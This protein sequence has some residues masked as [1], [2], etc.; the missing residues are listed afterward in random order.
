MS[1]AGRRAA[2][3]P[4]D[5]ELVPAL[6]EAH[7]HSPVTVTADNLAQCR[8][9]ELDDT[10]SLE[11]LAQGGVEVEEW[12]V[13]GPEGAP[14]I[15]LLIIRPPG[16]PSLP[17]L[18]GRRALPCLYHT[19]GGGMIMGNNRTGLDRTLGWVT[20]PGLVIVSVE[21]RLA[22]EHPFPAGVE[23]CYAGLVWTASHPEELGIDPQ[24]LIVGGGSAGG[25][26]A[27]ACALMARDRGGPPLAGQ[28]LIYPMIDDRLATESTWE[29]DGDGIWDGSSN[30]N[31][32]N[33]LLGDQRGS[34]GVSPYAAPARRRP[35]RAAPRLHRT[36]QRGNLPG[37]GPGLRPP[38]LGRR[39]GRRTARVARRIPRLRPD[40]PRLCPDP[41]RAGGPPG[42]APPHPFLLADLVR[43]GPAGDEAAL[44]WCFDGA[45]IVPLAHKGDRL[46]GGHAVEDGQAG[47]GGTGTPATAG[48]GDLDPLGPGPLPG[49]G[50][51]PAQA[52]LVRRQAEVRPAN[53]A[54]LPGHGRR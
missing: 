16:E 36:G 37:R 35:V 49:L 1:G 24:R 32:W 27:A 22:P 19:H 39:R 17:G 47:Q 44:A 3:P 52:G 21:Y 42:L 7:Q 14:D 50:Q 20:D 48:T 43:A 12:T 25:G 15:S 30:E 38:P 40:R 34:E 54:R 5:P 23:D 29:L 28:M 8:A 4:F 33:M 13:P 18:P 11:S 53:P 45:G 31:A 10:P 2:H 46:R 41:L 51:C 6:E 9:A 26:L